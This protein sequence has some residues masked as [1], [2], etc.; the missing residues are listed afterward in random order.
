MSLRKTVFLDNAGGHKGGQAMIARRAAAQRICRLMLLQ[1]TAPLWTGCIA[2]RPM[3]TPLDVLWDR[4]ATIV[5]PRDKSLIVFLPGAREAP[6]DLVDEG[7]VQQVR[8]RRIAADMVIADLH[9]GYFRSRDFE[10]RLREDVLA[11]ARAQGYRDIWL[12]GISLG[13]FASLMVSRLNDGAGLVDGII[14]LAPY[15]ARTSVLHEVRDAGGIARWDAAVKD[16]DFERDLLRWLKGYA[17]P[18]AKRPALYIGYGSRDG[19]ADFEAAMAGALPADRLRSAPGGHAWEP[20]KQLWAAFLDAAP[21][22][23]EPS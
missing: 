4:H 9:L 7:F 22:L 13:G 5:P 20:W 10:V 6:Q 18:R 19:F 23:R 14:A 12:A 8:Q 11:P 16:G 15:V 1:V 17:D 21:L 3:R 2:R